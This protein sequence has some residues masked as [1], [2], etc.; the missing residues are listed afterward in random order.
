M[1]RALLLLAIAAVPGCVAT[2]PADPAPTAAV[3][4]DAERE[5]HAVPAAAALVF[6]PPLAPPD[7]DPEL[8]RAGRDVWAFGGYD[9]FVTEYY[10]VRTDDRQASGFGPFG[11]NGDRYERRAVSERVGVR[12]R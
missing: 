2:R 3:S 6:R 1:K 8:S 12:H 11:F 7:L 5:Y 9:E 10:Y 4:Q